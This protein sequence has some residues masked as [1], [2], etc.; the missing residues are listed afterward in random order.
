[1]RVKNLALPAA[2]SGFRLTPPAD[3]MRVYARPLGSTRPAYPPS[4]KRW[5]IQYSR[6]LKSFELPNRGSQGV[7]AI[8]AKTPVVLADTNRG[9]LGILGR[10]LMFR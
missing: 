3:P 5:H 8:N 9:F 4:P 7:S 2:L 1:M 10:R 6:L